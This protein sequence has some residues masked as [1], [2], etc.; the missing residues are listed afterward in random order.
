VFRGATKQTGREVII[1]YATPA[2][3]LYLFLLCGGFSVTATAQAA[4]CDQVVAEALYSR[5]MEF[6][7]AGD[8]READTLLTLALER[9]P[10]YAD[11]LLARGDAY[12]NIALNQLYN[13]MPASSLQ[14]DLRF[15]KGCRE[16]LCGLRRC[17][18]WRFRAQSTAW[19]SSAPS[20]FQG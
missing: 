14:Q 8:Y 7:Q 11:A 20:T 16:N 12:L 18:R 17:R 10:K 15:R 5:A 4:D 3:A 9:K 6:F 2:S 13:L 19:H 1:D